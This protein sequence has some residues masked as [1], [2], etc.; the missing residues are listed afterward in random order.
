LDGELKRGERLDVFVKVRSSRPPQ[1]AWLT[2]GDDGFE[3]EFVGGEEGVA[4]GQ[5]CVLYD[6]A[7]GQAR[8]LGGGFIRM[9]VAQGETDAPVLDV[10]A[11]PL[12]AR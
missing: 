8:M 6:G 10:S 5:A 2:G 3:V 12:V 11:L 9:A 7:A 1:A 4:P